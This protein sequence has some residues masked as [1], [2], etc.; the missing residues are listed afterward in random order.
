MGESSTA[1]VCFW[2]LD[3]SSHKYRTQ[4]SQW[5]TQLHNLP[6]ILKYNRGKINTSSISSN[7]K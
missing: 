6:L 2:I 7:T 1:D 5:D 4:C 3:E